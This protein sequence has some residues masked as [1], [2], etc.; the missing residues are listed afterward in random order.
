MAATAN[1]ASGRPRCLS[2]PAVALSGH[3]TLCHEVQV[4]VQQ[5][6]APWVEGA[7]EV[8]ICKDVV[9][10]Q[11][12]HALTE[13]VAAILVHAKLLYP[14]NVVEPLLLYIPGYV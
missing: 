9:I 11:G 10:R 13:A 12:T 14:Y 1:R 5:P 6:S 2:K 4:C 8:F 7:V 3:S